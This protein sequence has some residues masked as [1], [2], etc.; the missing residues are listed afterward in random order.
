MSNGGTAVEVQSNGGRIA[1]QSK[2]IRSCNRCAKRIRTNVA[3]VR[4]HTRFPQLDSV[5]DMQT[6][7]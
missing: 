2:W 1:V 5:V 3:E 6:S 4:D 7:G